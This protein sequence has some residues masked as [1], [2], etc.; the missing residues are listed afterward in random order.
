MMNN[1]LYRQSKTSKSIIPILLLTFLSIFFLVQVH[2]QGWS[3]TFSV[4]SSGPCGASLPYIQPFTIPYLSTQGQCESLRQTVLSIRVSQPMYDEH[5][6]FIGYCSVFYTAT[7]CTGADISTSGGEFSPG[8]V[9]IDGLLQGSAF[10]TP[11][12]TKELE[13]WMNDYLVKMKSMGVTIEPDYSFTIQDIPL[14]GDKEFDEFYASQIIGFEKPE[15]GGTVYLNEP[16]ANISPEPA[17]K[18]DEEFGTTVQLLRTNEDIAR[19]EQW[20]AEHDYFSV[21]QIGPDNTMDAG[22]SDPAEM[23]WGEAVVREYVGNNL[24]GSL[25]LNFVDNTMEGVTE[26]T[27]SLTSGDFEGAAEKGINLS[28]NVAKTSTVDWAKDQATDLVTGAA[29]APV[30]GLVK[31]ADVV[32]SVINTFG[33]IWDTKHGK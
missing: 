19:E 16:S 9:S 25:V 5:N 32:V 2:A 22:G 33:S 24:A 27:Q 29:V 21:S 11:H 20:L 31:N 15:Q 30:L 23:S 8:S 10:F 14:T 17:S 26:V 28:E 12:E 4:T 18:A 3:F 1:T 6:N 13:N 7:P